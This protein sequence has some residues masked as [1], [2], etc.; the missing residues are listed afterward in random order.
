M[1]TNTFL[2]LAESELRALFS[3]AKAK[4]EF[5]FVLALNPEFRGIQDIGWSPAQEVMRS[6]EDFSSFLN[7]DAKTRIKIRAALGFYCNLCE[8][9]GLY[10][11]PKNM[12]RIIDGNTHHCWP[13]Q[14][15]VKEHNRTGE[16]NSPNAHKIMKN[17]IGH[18]KSLNKDALVEVFTHAF[19]TSLRHAYA[20]ADY[21]IWEDGIRICGKN[22]TERRLVPFVVF[23][24]LL[25]RAT[26]FFILLTRISA[27][28]VQSYSTPKIISGGFSRLPDDQ[29]LVSFD[30]SE[31]VFKIESYC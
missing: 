11:V 31:G 15:L 19:D 26:N 18:A 14:E 21:V 16:I 7:S 23:Q 28:H 27:E 25:N 4:A 3:E 22:F 24:D 5:D 13:F 8:A 9:S 2:S 17:M 29:S 1:D 6:I 12:L 20:H 30:T 10:E